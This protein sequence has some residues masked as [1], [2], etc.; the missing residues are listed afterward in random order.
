MVNKCV[1][2]KFIAKWDTEIQNTD[3]GRLEFY[4]SIKNT[5]GF[6]DYLE[7]KN[8]KFRKNIAK[9]R[10]SSH[11]LEIEKGR[12][13]NKLRH[14]RIC[15]ACSLNQVETEE[16]FLIKCPRYQTLRDNYTLTEFTNGNDI[17]TFTTPNLLGHFITEAFEIR[18]A[19]ME[20]PII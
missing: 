7:V 11:I 6:E 1:N 5:F 10:C 16:H 17:F 18:K 12:H 2:D 3:P 4:K 15:T 13:N 9:I 19:T 14:E 20:Q 8:F